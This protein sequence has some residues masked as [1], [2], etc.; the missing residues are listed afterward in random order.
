M[1][2]FAQE[3]NFAG[4]E[5]QA[6]PGGFI[7]SLRYDYYFRQEEA[8]T[9]RVGYQIIRHG[10]LGRHDDERGNG[11]GFSLGYKK[12]LYSSFSFHLRNDLWWN[13]IDW[14]DNRNGI[15]AIGKTDL[16]V[17][18]PTVGIEYPIDLGMD[19]VITPSLFFGVEWNVK[20]QGEATGEGA[21]GLLGIFLSKK[22]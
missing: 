10:D 3:S 16:L 13:K 9:L 14:E 20:T 22:L 19:I 18:Q 15:K 17:V 21:I 6:Y 8:L 2:V 4:L 12:N 7:P 5:M 1:P 11:A